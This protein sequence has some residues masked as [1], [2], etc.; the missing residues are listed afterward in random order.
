MDEGPVIRARVALRVKPIV[1][2]IAMK[3]S[4]RSYFP[5]Y[6]AYLAR[7]TNAGYRPPAKARY[8][9]L[10]VNHYFDQD[11]AWLRRAGADVAI[12]EVS[13]LPFIEAALRE[14]PPWAERFPGY[15]D[16]SIAD[17][18]ERYRAHVERIV[19]RL[20]TDIGFDAIAC[21]SDLFW[22]NRVFPEVLGP[23]GIPFVVIE[24]EGLMTPHFFTLY[25]QQF[26]EHAPP[27]ADRHLVWSQRQ[28]DFYRLCGQRPALIEIT[29][30][31]RSDFWRRPE[32]WPG[33]ETMGLPL[34]EGA[35]L[36]VAFDYE[37][38]FY[39]PYE[40]YERGEFSWKPLRQATA[41]ALLELAATRPDV[42]FVVKLHPMQ[43]ESAF[44]QRALPP[45]LFIVG[46]AKLGNP[47]L[48]HGD[49]LVLFQSTATVEAMTRDC[50][51]VYPFFG[52][53]ERY[54]PLMLLFHRD[55][56]TTVARSKDDIV[57]AVMAGLDSR[58]I[59]AEMSAR[60][61]R[62]LDEYLYKVDGHASRRVLDA[63]GR[64]V[65]ER[66]GAPRPDLLP[67]AS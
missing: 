43:D 48:L 10:V 44:G 65:D 30:Q 31:P 29:G 51:I 60:R 33:R 14:L 54:E 61:R 35:P 42:D 9:L 23:R 34:R 2:E 6:A 39:L 37:S 5:A 53:A 15:Y 17:G 1:R 16:P 8:R 36:V 47:L 13:F 50:P 24:K 7:K 11:I 57:D 62:F 55:E 38:W 67:A 59:P 63:I 56:I 21:T 25:S 12:F 46:G 4:P 64:L 26:R 32:E 58:I 27:I 18:R 41:D 3:V 45:N 49:V 40:M 20:Q 22:W 66:A 52:D 19:D 28:A